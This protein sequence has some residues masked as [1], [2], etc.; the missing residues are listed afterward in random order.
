[1]WDSLKVGLPVVLTITLLAVYAPNLLLL[2]G[3][4]VALLMVS[5]VVGD[6]ARN[7]YDDY[8]TDKYGVKKK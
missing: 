3:G 2:I 4:I 8:T 6:I 7:L 1:M 5:W